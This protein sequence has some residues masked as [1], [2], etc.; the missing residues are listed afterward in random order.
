[1]HDVQVAQDPLLLLSAAQSRDL[2]SD[3]QTLPR[4]QLGERALKEFQKTASRVEALVW[5]FCR[6]PCGGGQGLFLLQ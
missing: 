2:S 1:M 5:F 6:G 3:L 4:A